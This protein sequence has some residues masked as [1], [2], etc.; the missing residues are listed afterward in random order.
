VH[1]FGHRNVQGLAFRP[2]T[3]QVF[4]VEHGPDRD[5]EVNLLRAGGNS[6]WAPGCPY[7]ESV[8][9]TDLQRFPD[10]MQA[11]WTSG[12]PT[13]APSGAVF[14]R[15]AGWREWDGGLAV[16]MLKGAHL[17]LL[18]LDAAGRVS[19]ERSLLSDHGRLRSVTMA[20]DGTLLVTTANGGGRDEILRLT[21]S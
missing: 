19:A 20:R 3:N 4:S 10:A 15:G 18:F 13:V 1:T 7:A 5:D 16:A 12:R 14:L 9:M 6:G 21:P 11:V 8:P 2:G 17:R